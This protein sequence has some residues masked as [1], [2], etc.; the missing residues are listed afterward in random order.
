VFVGY[1]D[2]DNMRKMAKQVLDSVK[3]GPDPTKKPSRKKGT[4]SPEP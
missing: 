1:E 2:K 3:I 4:R